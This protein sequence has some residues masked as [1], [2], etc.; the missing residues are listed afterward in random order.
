[1]PAASLAQTG[2]EAETAIVVAR[3][4]AFASITVAASVLVYYLAVSIRTILV[5]TYQDRWWY[6]A[7]GVAAAIV[8]GASGLVELGTASEETAAAFRIGATLFFFLFSAVG[9]RAL[10]ATVKLDR[11]DF[12]SFS[13]PGWA[14]YVVIG[15]FV[16]AWW[17]AY[18]SDT[19]G[20][21][22]LV[23]AVGLAG[24]VT[25]TLA[26]AVLTV[27]DAEGTAIA[28]I[29][30]QFVPALVGFTGVVVAEQAGRYTAVDPGVV[31]GVELVGTVLVGA[32]LF[33]TAVAIRQQGE[34]VGRMYDRTTWR[35]QEKE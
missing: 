19:G 2:T 13:I 15:G 14:W 27:R 31:I 29:L 33:T 1:M 4:I 32:F 24:A 18:L 9:M 5:S 7:V 35:G 16:V 8:Y 10:Y 21:V 26:F 22:A 11:G 20:V 12:E 17:G 28:A 25:Y 30:R 34:E 6:L 3:A 23:E